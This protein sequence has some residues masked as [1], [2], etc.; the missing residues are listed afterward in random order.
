MVRAIDAD[1]MRYYDRGQERDRLTAANRLELIRTQ[2]L[3]TRLLPE[4]PAR[5]L[6]VGGGPGRY[7]AWLASLGHDVVLIDPVALH[8]DQARE[9]GGFEA[10][11]GDARSLDQPDGSADMVLLM[12][13]LY[14]LV[15]RDERLRAWREAG[16]V[17]RPGGVVAAALISRFAALLDGAAREFSLR[18]GFRA[19]AHRSTT[20]GVLQGGPDVPFTTAYFHHPDEIGD[21]VADAGLELGAVFGIEGPGEWMPDVDARL[22]DEARRE[23]LLDLARRLEREPSVL[24][25]SAHLLATARRSVA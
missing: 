20:T 21:E 24:G 11:L 9:L 16:R 8:V 18:P 3:L 5:I 12:G 17:V 2:E 7:S 23:V 1:V 22:D 10:T 13:P 6:D 15:D 4:T 19:A 25:V 14:H